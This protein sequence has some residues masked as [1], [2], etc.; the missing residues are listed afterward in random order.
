[1]LHFTNKLS[2][3][4][5]LRN[6]PAV[7]HSCQAGDTGAIVMQPSN[8]WFDELVNNTRGGLTRYVGRIVSSPEDVQEVVQ[9]AYLKV[10]I[11]LRKTRPSGHSPVAL[12]YRTAR[13]LALSRLRHMKVV[14]RTAMAVAV[15]E[16]LRTD[17]IT[18]EQAASAGQEIDTMLRVVNSLPPKCRDVFVLRWIHGKGQRQIGEQLGIAVSTVEKHLAKGLRLCKQELLRVPETGIVTISKKSVAGGKS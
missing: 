15:V 2:G 9:E 5:R 4:Y 8:E 1:L 11:A 14:N 16:E 6:N 18:I 7:W 13:N 17:R 12:L 3:E 10:F